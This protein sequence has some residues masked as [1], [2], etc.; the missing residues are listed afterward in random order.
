MFETI[1]DGLQTV[2]GGTNMG[3][4]CRPPRRGENV[5]AGT[6]ICTPAPPPSEPFH[7]SISHADR[8]GSR[9]R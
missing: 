9:G 8:A 4:D 1:A 3:R 2:I 6:V 5:P 7:G